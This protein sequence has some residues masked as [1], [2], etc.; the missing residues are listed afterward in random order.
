MSTPSTLYTG[1]MPEDLARIPQELTTHPQWVLWQGADRIDKQTGAITG[2]EKIPVNPQTLRKASTTNPATWGTFA[3]CVAALPVA[4]EAWECDNPTSYRGGG[5]G[6]VFS[7]T[8]PYAGLDLD[9]CVDAETHTIDAWAH[10]YIEDL[11]SYTEMTP[12]QTGLHILVVSSLPPGGRKKGG[13]ELYD[14]GRFFPVT[15][16][17]VASTPA[18]IEPR[19]EAVTRLHAQVFGTP[20]S[21]PQ[22]GKSTAPALLE[23]TT[24]LD[25]A[26]AAKNRVKFIRLWEGDT[27]LHDH[28][29]SRADLA[30]VIELAFWTQ[31][32][33]QIDRLFR[34]SGLMRDKWGARRGEQTYGARTIQAALT[35]QTDHYHPP[36]AVHP[37]PAPGAQT[38]QERLQARLQSC[39]VVRPTPSLSHAARVR[40]RIRSLG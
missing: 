32:P 20:A 35:R 37:S 15:G 5:L 34:S 19:Q 38:Y 8:D 4:L 1:P 25:K 40:A 33:A 31:D 27:S 3:H 28:D 36:R 21:A 12:S 11:R 30:L 23:D 17:H 39:A 18:T 29:E 13:V 10:A 14:Q 9:H 2:L 26:R 6:Y 24:L 22:Q 7:A 16:W